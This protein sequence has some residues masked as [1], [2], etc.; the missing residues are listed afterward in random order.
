MSARAT[1]VARTLDVLA[2]LVPLAAYASS[3]SP[4]PDGWDNGEYETVPYILGIAHPTGFPAFVLLGWI[5]SHAFA[6]GTVA[7]RLK[8]FSALFVAG[9]ALLVRRLAIAFG[10]TE[11][12]AFAAGLVFACTSVAWMKALHTDV[13]AMALFFS[14][15]VFVSAMAYAR[16]QNPRAVVIAAGAFGCGLATHPN[17]MW[18]G[19]ALIPGFFEVARRD[20]R[21]AALAV[22]AAIVPMTSY[23]YLPIRSAVIEANH[24]DPAEA[25]PM[26]GVGDVAWDIN[27]PNTLS[28]FFKEVLGSDSSNAAFG[29][30]LAFSRYPA[31]ALDWATA[32][33]REL[34]VVAIV[35]AAV[36][37]LSL[38]RVP[39]R[40]RRGALFVIAGAFAAVPFTFSFGAESD[41]TRYVF[42]SLAVSLALAACSPQL[43]PAP[44]LRLASTWIVSLALL[45]ILASNYRQNAYQFGTRND[46][47]GQSTIDDAVHDIPDGA[48]VLSNWIDLTPLVY[49]AYVD[50][51]FGTRVPLEYLG[52]NVSLYRDWSR[53]HDVFA[54]TNFA[55]HDEVLRSFPARCRH[56]VADHGNQV[57]VF[58]IRCEPAPVAVTTMPI[59][60]VARRNTYTS[61]PR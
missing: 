24:L 39:S 14:L 7:L 49:A 5:F 31:F 12:P 54:M 50:R 18:S 43:A 20:R 32:A 25:A 57:V 19:L 27:R 58:R 40:V 44:R 2:F 8:L 9:S 3:L 26:L 53:T 17:V 61:A 13:H 38:S 33:A 60:R 23:A 1:R 51:S 56:L 16:T 41:V 28:G 22:V 46:R 30:F 15:A 34:T 59:S 52:G 42:A 45:A 10:A 48:I 36:G 21:M 6:I 37:A 4:W 55:N 47:E 35:L 29:G 11:I